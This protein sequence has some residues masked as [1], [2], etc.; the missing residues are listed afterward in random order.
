MLVLPALAPVI[1][2]A[3]HRVRPGQ[4][5]VGYRVAPETHASAPGE[6]ALVT[7]LGV[8]GLQAPV[9]PAVV[10]VKALVP[11]MG[12]QALPSRL[13]SASTRVIVEDPRL[14]TSTVR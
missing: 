3:H 2:P 5:V 7:G 14:N 9:R 6:N 13:N 12:N 4:L 1:G 8:V 10:L 11:G